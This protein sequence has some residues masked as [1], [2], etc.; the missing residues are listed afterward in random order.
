MKSATNATFNDALEARTADFAAAAAARS[1]AHDAASDAYDEAEATAEALLADAVQAHSIAMVTAKR[2]ERLSR[3]AAKAAYDAAETFARGTY[4][5]A[6][7]AYALDRYKD[8]AFAA[9]LAVEEDA[10]VYAMNV[11]MDRGLP[12]ADAMDII[13]CSING[14]LTGVHPLSP[15]RRDVTTRLQST[16]DFYS[17]KF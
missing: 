4:D 2:I 11:L 1:A 13:K 12:S 14:A 5:A 15:T 7:I 6:V 16:V 9:N 3:K 10:F 8:A 17:D